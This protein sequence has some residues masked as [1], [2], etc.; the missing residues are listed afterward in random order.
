MES[1]RVGADVFFPPRRGSA[2]AGDG[3]TTDAIAAPVGNISVESFDRYGTGIAAGG[4]FRCQF[5]AVTWRSCYD[6]RC[7]R[8]RQ[9]FP[10]AR[11][12][13]SLASRTRLRTRR[14]K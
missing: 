12:G 1:V 14:W 4:D 6:R 10:S 3:K 11:A 2:D 8:F 9:I 5:L 13:W 7:V